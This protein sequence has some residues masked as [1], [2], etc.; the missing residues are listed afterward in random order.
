M[1]AITN[2]PGGGKPDKIIRDALLAVARNEPER[3]KRLAKAWWDAAETDQTARN[4]L[5]DRLDGKVTDTIAVD[6][7][8]K[9]ESISPAVSRLIDVLGRIKKAPDADNA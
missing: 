4:A 2:K 7:T 6:H 1:V 9:G 3:I 5:S 8:S